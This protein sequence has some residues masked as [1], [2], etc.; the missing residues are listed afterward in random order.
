M[1]AEGG[2]CASG[3]A[4][5]RLAEDVQ[6]AGGTGSAVSC[7]LAE[8]HA[9]LRDWEQSGAPGLIAPWGGRLPGQFLLSRAP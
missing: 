3:G 9:Q 8:T 2:L 1:R 4:P 6:R 7:P 5:G